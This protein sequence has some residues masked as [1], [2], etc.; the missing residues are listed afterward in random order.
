MTFW[1]LLHSA[2]GQQHMSI[3]ADLQI[4]QDLEVSRY[5]PEKSLGLCHLGW[6]VTPPKKG[7]CL[8]FICSYPWVYK[9]SHRGY[10]ALK[11]YSERDNQFWGWPS[12]NRRVR[13][14]WKKTLSQWHSWCLRKFQLSAL[15]CYGMKVYY[16][17]ACLGKF[18]E[19]GQHYISLPSYL[20][21]LWTKGKCLRSLLCFFCHGFVLSLSCETVSWFGDWFWLY[22]E[23]SGVF[24]KRLQYGSVLKQLKA[25]SWKKYVQGSGLL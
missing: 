10:T 16:V 7:M 4:S 18:W 2:V 21:I 14:C 24:F 1:I 12:R 5:Q 9:T 25:S 8:C 3:W 11:V 20:C 22:C 13:Y 19:E 23:G 6:Q 17:L 15:P